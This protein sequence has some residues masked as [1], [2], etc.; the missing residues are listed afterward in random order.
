MSCPSRDDL[1][2][3]VIGGLSSEEERS[4]ES[5]LPGCERC[6]REL[7]ALA[8]AVAA[9]GESVEQLEPPPQLREGVLATVREEA[10]RPSAEP[11]RER[12]GLSRFVLR[13]AAGL[14]A[15]A[16]AGAGVAGY[17]IADEGGG[18]GTDGVPIEGQSGI[19]GELQVSDGSAT[20]EVSGMPQPAKGSIYQVWVEQGEAVRP[21]SS[22]VPDQGGTATAAVSADLKPGDEVLVTQETGPGRQAPSGPPVLTARVD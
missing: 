22:F 15:L 21:A 14:A 17:L 18:G 20:L 10:E 13:P 19:G 12:R 9:L 5:H 6:A 16:V 4:L 1:A 8:P 7:R 3:Y 2:A 11:A